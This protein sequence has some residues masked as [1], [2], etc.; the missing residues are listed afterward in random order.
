MSIST[1]E[2]GPAVLVLGTPAVTGPNG[3]ARVS[4][5]VEARLLAALAIAAL[6]GT[7]LTVELLAEQ[8]WGTT[9]DEGDYGRVHTSVSRLRKKIDEGFASPT[10]SDK[11]GP[12]EH[13]R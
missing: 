5:S 9:G 10:F 13:F 3:T 8:A 1:S 6:R 4:G 12:E 7:G 11:S 2:L